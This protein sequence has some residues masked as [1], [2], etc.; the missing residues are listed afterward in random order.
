M[1]L[2]DIA[3]NQS[4]NAKIVV[5]GVGGGGCNA[6]DRMIEDNVEFIDFIAVNTDHQVLEMSK[7]PIRIQIGEKLTRGLGAGGRP[8]IGMKA[9]EESTDDI[10]QTLSGADMVFVTAGMGGGTGTGAAP[11]VAKLA[12]EQG[13]LTV[14]VVTKPFAFEGKKRMDNAV[15]GI[16]ELKKSVDTLIIIPNQR[17]LDIIEKDTSL[18]DSFKKA[19]EVL[20]QGVE[21]IASLISK[22]GVI[23]LDFADVRTTMQN[24]GVAHMG[25]G[26]ASGKNKAEAAAKA[27]INSP[28][29]ETSMKGAKNVLISISGDENLTLTDTELA[30]GIINTDTDVEAEIILGTSINNDLEDEVVITV[31]ATGLENEDLPSIPVFGAA[32]SQEN[33]VRT[34]QPQPQSQAHIHNEQPQQPEEQPKAPDHQELRPIRDMKKDAKFVIPDFLQEKK[35]P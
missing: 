30:A 17:L 21:G 3:S 16:E 23:N 25:V 6:V 10:N 22:P 5:I 14:G 35:R 31:I 29:L 4:G 13:I 20:R 11:I 12:K 9:A 19:D 33:P 28:L 8:E 34:Q 1:V 15:K 18:K 26:R 2:I 32:Q 27:A 24:K 7:A